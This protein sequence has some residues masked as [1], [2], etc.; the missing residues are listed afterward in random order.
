MEK[1]SHALL[2]DGHLANLEI[3][4]ELQ[5]DRIVLYGQVDSYFLKQIAQE[6]AKRHLEEGLRIDNQ[7]VVYN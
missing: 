4:V 6:V 3:S 7:I 5:N 1:I 2:Q